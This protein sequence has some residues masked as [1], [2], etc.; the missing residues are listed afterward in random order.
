[1][2]A[3]S[4][5]IHQARRAHALLRHIFSWRRTLSN[6][7]WCERRKRASCHR[8]S[9]LSVATGC[10]EKA[11]LLLVEQAFAEEVWIMSTP[12]RTPRRGLSQSPCRPARSHQKPT[13]AARTMTRAATPLKLPPPSLQHDQ[14]EEGIQGMCWSL[15]VSVAMSLLVLSHSHM[16]WLLCGNS[17]H[18]YATLEQQ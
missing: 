14:G 13:S 2:H 9:A 10:K 7:G 4:R 15:I 18:S 8:A 17:C 1:M 16:L 3:P 11:I 5:A 6:T 12:L